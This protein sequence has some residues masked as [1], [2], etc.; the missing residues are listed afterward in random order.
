MERE[1]SDR[2]SERENIVRERKRE[3][4]IVRRIGREIAR[5]SKIQ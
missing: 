4:Y 5:K 1:E 2:E 3:S